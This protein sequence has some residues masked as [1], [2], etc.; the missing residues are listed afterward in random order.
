MKSSVEKMDGLFRRVNVEIP[1]QS[2]SNAFDRVYKEIQKNANIKGFR[3]GKVPLST[4]KTMYSDQVKQDVI[5]DLINENYGKAIDEHSLTPIGNP[6]IRLGEFDPEKDFTFAAEFEIRPEVALKKVD[7]LQIEKPKINISTDQV[8]QVLENIRNSQAE[9][10][11][12]F[13]DRTAQEGDVAIIDFEGFVDGQ[14]LP[15]GQGQGHPLELGAHQFIE[16]FEEG[17][18]GLKPGA[19]KELNLKFPD[20]YHGK[21]VAGKDVTFKV[22]LKELKK[23]SLP[24]L[25]DELAKKAGPFQTLVELKETI[26]KDLK[27]QAE[28]QIQE[29][30]KRQLLRELV[31]SNPVEVPATLKSEQKLM[32]IE[33][34]KQRMSQQGMSLTEF[35]DYKVKWDSDFDDS[36]RFMIQSTFLV[37][38]IATEYKLRPNNEDIK[39]KIETMAEQTGI[40]LSRLNE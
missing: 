22:T 21:E 33:D 31:Q 28:E 39:K 14:P 6:S 25:N 9:T 13:E 27:A 37:D 11:P 35:E 12:V 18:V 10:V 2:V 16:G 7:G 15:N 8:G 36:A 30:V 20:E 1:A 26:E 5:N 24:E 38:A 40:E 4:V 32:L 23:K 3:R 17:I 34:V 19:Q 29:D